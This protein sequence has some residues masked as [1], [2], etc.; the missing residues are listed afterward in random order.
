MCMLHFSYT[1]EYVHGTS[2]KDADALS[3][4]PVHTPSIDDEIGEKD[5]ACHVNSL[6]D[7]IPATDSRLSEIRREVKVD[8]SLQEV[9]IVKEK[10]SLGYPEVQLYCGI[11]YELTYINGLPLR[12]SRIVI[13][14]S[15]CRS[16]LEKIHTGHLKIEK[17]RRARQSVY[18]PVINKQV[19]QMIKRCQTCLELLPSKKKGPLNPLEIPGKPWE[20]WVQ[21]FF[22]MGKTTI[23]SSWII[24]PC[25][26]RY[27]N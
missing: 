9:K 3:R 12:G 7:S 4:A 24:T 11:Q 1:A 20:K 5:I 25:G 21:T 15:L 27:I 22:N 6:I 26:Q 18:W 19:D 10:K 8:K 2:L 17:C 23:L 14:K 16:I 13:P